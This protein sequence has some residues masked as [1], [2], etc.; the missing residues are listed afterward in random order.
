MLLF[1]WIQ[2]PT[3]GGLDPPWLQVSPALYAENYPDIWHNVQTEQLAVLAYCWL[4][5]T[6]WLPRKLKCPAGDICFL[7][8]HLVPAAKSPCILM[9]IS[10]SVLWQLRGPDATHAT[11]RDITF[12]K[13]WLLCAWTLVWS[14]GESTHYEIGLDWGFQGKKNSRLPFKPGLILTSRTA[15]EGISCRG[16]A[17][18][19]WVWGHPL[20]FSSSFLVVL[21]AILLGELCMWKAMLHS[22]CWLGGLLDWGLT[23]KREV[24]KVQHTI[25]KSCTEKACPPFSLSAPEAEFCPPLFNGPIEPSACSLYL[26]PHCIL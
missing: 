17:F 5:S 26:R 16:E 19:T 10:Q 21:Q 23:L 8:P 18:C 7:A 24:D 6:L 1:Y 25:V 9:V 3:H 12:M 11:D 4:R 2:R 20:W 15:L 22:L 13:C 14:E